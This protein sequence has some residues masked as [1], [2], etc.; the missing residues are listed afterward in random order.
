MNAIPALPVPNTTNSHALHPFGAGNQETSGQGLPP[1]AGVRPQMSCPR[2]LDSQ[3]HSFRAFFSDR[4]ASFLREN[5][6]NPEHVAVAFGVRYQTAL[7]WWGGV[8]SPSGYAV[9]AAFHS[10]P[11]SAVR[12]LSVEEP[13]Q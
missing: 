10:H 7:N 2:I 3:M 6:R 1:F 11:E 9:A 8:N 4:W 12:H 13:G 5:Y